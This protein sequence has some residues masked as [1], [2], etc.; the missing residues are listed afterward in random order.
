LEFC[1]R[2]LSCLLILLLLGSPGAYAHSSIPGAEGFY[3]GLT[4]PLQEPAQGLLVGMLGILIGRAEPRRMVFLWAA[5]CIVLVIGALLFAF[6]NA[7]KGPWLAILSA[8]LIGGL[9]AAAWAKPPVLVIVTILLGGGLLAGTNALST[10]AEG[11]LETTA[12]SL[13][14]AAAL[15]VYLAGA[16]HGLRKYEPRFLWLHLVPRVAGA[17]AAA[18]A[19]LMMAFAIRPAP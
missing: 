5:I 7:D 18:I 17:W 10:G 13:T 1:K 19:I 6:V 3:R 11:Q 2:A 16:T 9:A 14:G 8:L 12:G 4:H 15:S